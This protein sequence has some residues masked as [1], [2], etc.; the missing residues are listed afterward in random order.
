MFFPR[1]DYSRGRVAPAGRRVAA[2]STTQRRRNRLRQAAYSCDGGGSSG[3]GGLMGAGG[4][5]LQAYSPVYERAEDPTLAEE[6]LPTDTQTQNKIFRNIIMYDPVAGPAT[7]YWRDLAFSR[8]IRLGGLEDQKIL[9][10]YEDAIEASGVAGKMPWMLNDYLT[11]GRFVLHLVMD[12]RKGYWTQCII[13][14]PDYVE[15]RMSPFPKEDPVINVQP[16][17]EHRDWAVSRDPRIMEQ[18]DKYDPEVIKLMAVGEAYPLPSE[19]TLFMPRQAYATDYYG[20]SYLTRIIPFKIMEKALIDAE[21]AA[22]RRRAGPV[23]IITVPEHYE[24]E[25][26]QEIIDQMFA[27]EEDP[28]AGKVAVRE[29][30]TVTPFGGGKSDFWTLSDEYEFLKSAKLNALGI[31]DSFLDGSTT[32]ASMEKTVALFVEKLRAIRTLFTER[33]VVDKM[34]KGLARMHKYYEK[35]ATQVAHRYRIAKREI[36]DADLIIPT[37]EWDKPLEPHADL[38]FWDLLERLEQKGVPIPKRKWTQA[39][40]YDLAETFDNAEGDLQDRARLY[41]I[42]AAQAKQA[43]RAGF[44]LEGN[45]LGA[46]AGEIGGGPGGGFGDMGGEG[47]FDFGEPGG[48]ADFELPPGEEFEMGPELETPPA[49]MELPAAP[50]G[51]DEGMGASL[52]GARFPMRNT[53]LHRRH[54][55]AIDYRD[56]EQTLRDIDIWDQHDSVLGLPRRRVAQAIDQ[57]AHRPADQ[58]EGRHLRRLFHKEQLSGAQSSIIQY[59]AARLGFIQRP[60]MTDDGLQFL[61]HV[62]VD[63][64]NQAGLTPQLNRELEL[65][66]S[67]ARNRSKTPA[68][69]PRNVTSRQADLPDSKVLTGVL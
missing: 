2:V 39:A 16:T 14:D 30:V 3:I 41:T 57:I 61:Q 20:T 32:L 11:F 52:D 38:D 25:E 1:Y 17:N 7:E 45:Y 33:I 9:Q 50:A 51:G 37:V 63:K 27:V 66:T 19:H 49:D 21:I 58:R 29:G 47:G 12:D 60:D 31:N 53:P 34:L 56:L 26:I 62:L 55:E 54:A 18:R 42:K 67:V 28:I 22:A 44:D 13:H 59:C 15:I 69:G 4:A 43:E 24:A 8:Y 23:S 36:S 46:G 65:L 6:F 48:G 68:A 5:G 40:G 64:A 10:F 35:P